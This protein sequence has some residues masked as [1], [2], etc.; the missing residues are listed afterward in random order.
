MQF[1]TILLLHVQGHP[2]AGASVLPLCVGVT[3]F[4]F[5]LHIPDVQYHQ[6]LKQSKQYTR[7]M[8]A[9]K[10]VKFHFPHICVHTVMYMYA[11]S[12]CI[13]FPHVCA[14]E[15]LCFGVAFC[16]LP[17]PWKLAP[18]TKSQV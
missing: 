6:A 15:Q 10:T 18:G 1:L 8:Q 16:I 5:A 12:Q 9:S 11:W 13:R 4:A 17:L 7:S 2:C 3:F 14:P